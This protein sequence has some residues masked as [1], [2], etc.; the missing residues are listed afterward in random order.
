MLLQK[1]LRRLRETGHRVLIFSQFKMMLDVIED[2]LEV[3]GW[4]YVRL[5]SNRHPYKKGHR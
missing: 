5:V 3:E 1:M 2:F 4:D